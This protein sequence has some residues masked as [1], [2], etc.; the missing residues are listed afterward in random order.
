M[1]RTLAGLDLPWGQVQ[2]FQVDERVAPD[3]HPDRNA[4][5]LDVLPIP[6]RNLVLMPVAARSLDAAIRRYARRL[7]ERLDVVH[8]GIGDDGHTASWPPG[9]PVIDSPEAVGLCGEFNG[10]VR[11]TLTPRSVNS[12]RC[13]LVLA[14]GASKA[15][16]IER[17]LLRDRSLPIQRVQRTATVVVLDAAAASRLPEVPH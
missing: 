5:L 9:D 15:A 12:A 17:W 8:L 2:V 4:P 13:R 1:L 11:V 6:S 10:R 3:G 14:T 7:P 16:V